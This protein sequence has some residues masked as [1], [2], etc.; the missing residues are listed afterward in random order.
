MDKG[1]EEDI[2]LLLDVLLFP[3]FPPLVPLISFSG[4][5]EKKHWKG[6]GHGVGECGSELE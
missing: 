4:R 5:L 6:K 3:S 1:R 2:S